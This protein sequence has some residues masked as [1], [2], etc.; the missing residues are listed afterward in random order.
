[1]YQKLFEELRQKFDYMSDG[2]LQ[3]IWKGNDRDEYSLKELETVRQILI[4]RNAEVPEQD[5]FAGDDDGVSSK[6]E[7]NSLLRGA[8]VFLMIFGF[9]N[10][11][12]WYFAGGAERAGLLS[13]FEV[14]KPILWAAM[15]GE[16]V[17]SG[18]LIFMGLLCFLQ[19]D[20]IMIL[21]FSGM[22][23]MFSGLWNLFSNLLLIPAFAQYDVVIPFFKAYDDFKYFLF[24]LGVL[25]LRWG[26]N[27]IKDYFKVRK[28]ERENSSAREYGNTPT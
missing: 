15:Y 11:V 17:L 16:A 22:V 20:N 24:V 25:L 3:N 23:L 19:R 14:V 10:L 27:Q 6:D 4:V 12:Y 28:F 26:F 8:M 13:R 9:V 7:V 21:V 2:E 18:A 1:M 5:E